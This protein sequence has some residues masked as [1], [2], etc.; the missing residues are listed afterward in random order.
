M[1]I[2]KDRTCLFH[3]VAEN[4]S[5][6]PV[7]INNGD[8]ERMYK[9]IDTLLLKSSPCLWE[10]SGRYLQFQLELFDCFLNVPFVIMCNDVNSEVHIT[11]NLQLFHLMAAWFKTS[12][13]ILD[14][15][16]KLTEAE[17]CIYAS[18]TQAII[19]SD[20]GACSAP[21]HCLNQCC[22]VAILIIRNK[23]QSNCIRYSN[24]FIQEMQLEASSGK[25]R[26]FCLGDIVLIEK[27]QI[28]L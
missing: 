22:I 9:R 2:P 7:S 16:S 21:S 6:F 3:Y 14:P 1:A 27:L 20:N 10:G 12:L 13:L 25:F 11:A 24:I 5:R 18:P 17:W 28:K 19:G 15:Y 23:I 8:L 26:P 4:L